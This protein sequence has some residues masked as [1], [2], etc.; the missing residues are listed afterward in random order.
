M[1]NVIRIAGKELP[2][3][4]SIKTIIDYKSTFGTDIFEDL[5]KIQNVNANSIGS[6]SSI[7]NTSF[8][9]LYIL[10]KPYA[11]GKSFSDFLDEFEF[12]IFQETT[13]LN[14]LTGVFSLL[15]PGQKE[16]S[17]SK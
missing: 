13:S 14:E 7:I 12:S 11:K 4:V 9:I 2:I 1:D 16:E 8:Q 15:F 6:L 10:H 17:K 3:H 5:E